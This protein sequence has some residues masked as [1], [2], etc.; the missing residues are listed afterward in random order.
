MKRTNSFYD[1]SKT[2][3]LL[4]EL[5]DQYSTYSH[6]IKRSK[7]TKSIISDSSSVYSSI[8][9]YVRSLKDEL[10]HEKKARLKA[11]KVLESVQKNRKIV[12]D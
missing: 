8:Y 1:K 6:S 5:G 9:S 2:N 7:S 12:D 3:P 11:E 10:E 4:K